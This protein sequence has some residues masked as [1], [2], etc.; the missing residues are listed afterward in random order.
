MKKYYLLFLSLLFVLFGATANA[1]TSPCEAL[2]GESAAV[3]HRVLDTAY[4]YDCCDETLSKCMKQ[5][6]VCS[7]V[8]RLSNDVCRMASAGKSEQEIKHILDQRALTMTDLSPVKAIEKLPQ[9]I[10]GNPD[11]KVVLSVYL[12][13]RCPYCSRYV[14]E[15]I[16]ALDKSPLKQQVAVNM[17]LFP[18]KTHDHSAEVAYMIET[19]ALMG[20][21]WDF[22]LLN[23]DH[24]DKFS[25]SFLTDKVVEMGVDKETFEAN[26]KK[27]EVRDTVVA[28][29]KEGLKNG[30]E[31]TPTFFL[32]GRKIHGQFDVETVLSMLEEAV[33][34][35][36]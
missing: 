3:A 28:S 20:K 9:H 18:I 34:V 14:P 17:R 26:M 8:T 24:F 11:A 21:G 2:S 27:K 33:E 6:K 25:L 1:Q 7:L 22:L 12:C 13:G 31:S 5:A 23:Y 10:W 16:R 29:K 36:K 30:V 32:N 35:A 15:L 19:L 4:A